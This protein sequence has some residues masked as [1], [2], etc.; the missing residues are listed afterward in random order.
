[1]VKTRQNALRINS[2]YGKYVEVLPT[3]GKLAIFGLC[4]IFIPMSLKN[5]VID[6]SFKFK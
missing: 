6:T 4:P 3:I 2:L 5:F 1:M